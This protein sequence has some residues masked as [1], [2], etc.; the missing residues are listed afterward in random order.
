M[1][2]D[3]LAPGSYLALCHATN[4]GQPVVAHAV[5]EVYDRSVST[6]AYGRSRAEILR[7][8]RDAPPSRPQRHRS[9]ATSPVA[10]H[11]AGR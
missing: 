11:L 6:S 2:R 1:L 9:P 5:P 4:E 3:A 10:R 7:C 8:F